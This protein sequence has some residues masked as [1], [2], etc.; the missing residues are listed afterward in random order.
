MN[1]KPAKA[2]KEIIVDAMAYASLVHI[3]ER[4]V[5][6]VFDQLEGERCTTDVLEKVVANKDSS[7]GNRH[8]S[9]CERQSNDGVHS[10]GSEANS[11]QV[12]SVTESPTECEMPRSGCVNI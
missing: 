9:S 11:T 4:T 5:E 1:N 10:S 8:P 7:D 12:S 2:A 6:D 3:E